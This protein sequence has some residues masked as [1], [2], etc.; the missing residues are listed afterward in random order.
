MSPSTGH[1]WRGPAEQH[2]LHTRTP[3]FPTGADG[4]PDVSRRDLLQVV[5]AS[6]A[7][8]AATGCSRGPSR[9]IL[10]YARQP[11]EV[12]PSV[13]TGYATTMSLD[14]FGV[15][16]IV[17]S[18]EGRPTKPEGNPAHPASGGAL[19]TLQQ[20]SVLDLYDPARARAVTQSGQPRAWS[21]FADAISRAPAPGK[22]THVL[23]EPTSSPHV[24]DL[25]GRVRARG[26]KA[27]FYSPLARANVWA[28]ART[29][30]GRTVE[31][32]WDFSAASVVLSLDADFLGTQTTPMPAARAWAVRRRLETPGSGKSRLYAVEGRLSITGM[33]ADDRLRVQASQVGE[34]AFDLLAQLCALLPDAGA[35]PEVRDAA[36]ARARSPTP[37]ILALARDLAAHRGTSLVLAGDGQ[38]P[39]V[40]AATHAINEV[41]A[42]VGRTVL[43]APSPVFEAGEPSHDLEGLCAALDAGDVG[44]LVIIGGDPAYTAP[45]DLAFERRL[46]TLGSTAF[47]GPRENLTARTCT[48]FAPEAHFLESWSDARAFDGTASIVQ[49]LT[50]SACGARTPA[51]VLAALLGQPLAESRALVEQY[52]RAHATPDGFDA[53]WTESLA[54]GVVPRSGID[55]VA[56]HL[57]WRSVVPSLRAPPRPASPLEIIYFADNKVHDGRFADCACLQELADPVTKLTWDNAALLGPGTA[58]RLGIATED[59]VDLEVRGRKVRAPVLVCPSMA[60]DVVALALGYGQ[61]GKGRL[62]DGVG[63]DAYALRD[64]RAPWADDAMIRTTRDRWELAL[65]QE[66]WSMDGRP[67]VLSDTLDGFQR[68]PDLARRLNRATLS[69]YPNPPT[70]PHQWGMTIDLDACTGCSACVIACIA[71]NNI[72][73]VG[74]GGVRLSREMH[75]IRIDR[76]FSGSAVDARAVVQPMLCQHCEQAPCEYVCPVNAT[77]HSAD[78]LNEM[79]Y[80]RCVGT[81]FCSNNCP[82]KV[83]RFNFF[84]YT[85]DLPE[86]TQ[87]AMNPDVTVRARGVMEKCTYCVQRIR[88]AEIG[89]RREGRPIAD[90]DIV[91]ACEQT[92][93]T[94][95]IV[96]GDVADRSTRVS[97]TRTSDRLYAVLNELGTRPRTRYLARITNPNP[98]LGGA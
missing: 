67:L 75:W 70:A 4:P 80:N 61:R 28:G 97:A 90:G 48:W 83:R 32:R 6:A 58:E 43:Y 66:H 59:V 33:A 74:K 36:A 57:D 93:P 56:M 49:P 21:A 1:H 46:A 34:V 8:A 40:H 73:P 7:L 29:A 47:V 77:V 87:L 81:R 35:P 25:L 62:A 92:C 31:P 19:G 39:N 98:E 78:G 20:A 27:W 26:V 12:T 5:G 23:L 18:H 15:G 84:N 10:P 91:T 64:S 14:G 37:W 41:L 53:L 82:Y 79:V 17:R 54:H 44:T 71:E 51:Q 85:R 13:A 65:T 69:L 45:A 60:D 11:P 68:D 2:Q 89:A 86:T 72:P 30:F 96:F 95:A 94:G 52:W 88:E 50:S 63:V 38:P 16:M 55:P 9:D 22:S 76:Y 3:E 24:V 42:N